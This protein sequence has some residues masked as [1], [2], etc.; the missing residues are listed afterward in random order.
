LHQNNII[1]RDLK[2]QNI[3]VKYD[4]HREIKQ[5][6][7]G[8]FDAAKR[9]TK[10]TKAKTIVGTL[11]YMAPEVISSG[12][13]GYGFSADVWSFGMI[14]FEFLTLKPPFP[15]DEPIRIPERILAGDIPS[16]DDFIELSPDYDELVE[17]HERCTNIKPDQRPSINEVKKLIRK[18]LKTFNL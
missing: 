6:V 2:S 10:T 14:L 5:L 9:I 13:A 11:S 8:D 18:M 12:E 7:I 17:L 15:E 1:H 4:E 3:F 16:V